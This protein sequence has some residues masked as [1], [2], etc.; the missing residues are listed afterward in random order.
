MA[1]LEE[2]NREMMDEEERLFNQAFGEHTGISEDC[3]EDI[4][5]IKNNVEG[6]RMLRLCIS[7]ARRFTDLAWQLLGQ[8]I[9]N[10][11]ELNELDLDGC[12]LT[13]QQM[14]SLFSELVRSPLSELDIRNNSFGIDGV[15][16]M[17]PF[18]ENSPNL[19]V[20]DLSR[21]N[22]INSE[23]FEVLIKALR[24]RPIRTLRLWKCNITDI[25]AL[26]IYS[27]PNL[28]KFNLMENN[29][30]REGGILYYPTCYKKKIQC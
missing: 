11:T 29:I 1:S 20:I 7:D 23:C 13:D 21:N 26:E 6:A 14:A 2:S 27:L 8:Y 28:Q 17:I 4:R 12:D 10:D 30:G 9:S 16:C 15:R 22:N 24:G 5:F 25:S 18:L 3:R 19:S